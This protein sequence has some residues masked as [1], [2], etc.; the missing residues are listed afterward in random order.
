M[1]HALKSVS[2]A[3]AMVAAVAPAFA[4]G[5]FDDNE[6]RRRVE[7][8]RQSVETSQRAMEER[9][10]KLEGVASDR[11]ALLELASQLEALR[12]DMSR[13]RGQIEVISNQIGA[14]KK[15]QKGLYHRD[16]PGPRKRGESQ[17]AAGSE[18]RQAGGRG[19][20]GLA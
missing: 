17:G 16:G 20:R 19:S 2:L 8:L 11:G 3:V 7:L 10:T 15:R 13:M 12:G 14:A 6:A 18:G 9:M 1:R 4:Q 5:L